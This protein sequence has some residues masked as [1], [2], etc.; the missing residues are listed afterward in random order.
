MVGEEK[1]LFDLVCSEHCDDAGS[2]IPVDG[3]SPTRFEYS[4]TKVSLDR[5]VS[6][7]ENGT[8]LSRSKKVAIN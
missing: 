5:N 3:L 7:S 8:H 6:F 1:R 4:N 2:V